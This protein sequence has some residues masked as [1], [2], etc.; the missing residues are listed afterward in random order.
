[1][2]T[3]LTV[4]LIFGS[5]LQDAA[6]TA[7]P[8]PQQ[9]P[10]AVMV[11]EEFDEQLYNSES[12]GLETLAFDMEMPGPGGVSLGTLSVTWSIQDGATGVFEIADSMKAM[13]P[14]QALEGMHEQMKVASEQIAL[15]QTNGI[16]RDILDDMQVTL[17]G[18]D[19]GYVKVVAVPLVEGK[20]MTRTLLFEDGLLAK[21]IQKVKGPMGEME[22]TDI[23]EWE[24][25]EEGSELLVLGSTTETTSGMS[26]T[27]RFV[28]EKI[29]K[30]FFVTR[31]EG[32][33]MG[34]ASTIHF[35]NF[36]V[37]GKPIALEDGAEPELI[38]DVPGEG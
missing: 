24:A 20:G 15:I 3:L 26:Q 7:A 16:V 32:E 10:K 31:I 34:Q 35:T 9:D 2:F 12:D 23:M 29:G 25:L 14:A 22:S 37:N 17:E 11:L 19:G 36:I 1:M 5:L 27:S 38:E 28:R 6:P 30:F 13:V 21:T 18:V 33:A 4:S 8:A